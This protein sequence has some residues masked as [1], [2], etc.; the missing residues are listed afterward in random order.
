[1]SSS[2]IAPHLPSLFSNSGDGVIIDRSRENEFFT[3]WTKG[4]ATPPQEEP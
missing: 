4:S 2:I 3:V 1:V